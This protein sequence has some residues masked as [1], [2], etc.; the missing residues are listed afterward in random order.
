[1]MVEV[2]KDLPP[3]IQENIELKVWNVTTREGFDR[4]KQLKVVRIPSLTVNERVVF[5]SIPDGNQLAGKING[6]LL[7]SGLEN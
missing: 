3:N 4:K 1:M 5:E 2:V 6:I 7:E